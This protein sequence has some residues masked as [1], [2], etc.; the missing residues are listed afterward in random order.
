[1][2]L[3]ELLFALLIP[4]IPGLRLL[5]ILLRGRLAT[6]AAWLLLLLMLSLALPMP[7]MQVQTQVCPTVDVC[8]GDAIVLDGCFLQLKDKEGARGINLYRLLR[9]WTDGRC[10]S[11]LIEGIGGG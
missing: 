8:N 1:V 6:V 5:R 10:V 11:V 4:R 9:F 2:L 7:A 3:L